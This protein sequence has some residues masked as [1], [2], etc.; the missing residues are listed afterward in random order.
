MAPYDPAILLPSAGD[1]TRAPDLTKRL[2][3]HGRDRDWTPMVATG[4][5][6]PARSRTSRTSSTPSTER[7]RRPISG[8][9]R[10]MP[11]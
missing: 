7:I 8:F 5:G 9:W 1:A 6:P 3:T 4:T 2:E 10:G 11:V